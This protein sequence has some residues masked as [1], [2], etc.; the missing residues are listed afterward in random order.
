VAKFLRVYVSASHRAP[1]NAL[2]DALE[3]AGHNVCSL[4]HRDPTPAP[5][6][7]EAKEWQERTAG[8]FNMIRSAD[9]HV[10]ICDGLP[11]PGGKHRESGFAQGFAAG[12]KGTPRCAVVGP[13]ENGMQCHPAVKH[14]AAVEDVVAWVDG[15]AK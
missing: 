7:A 13:V 14:F 6:L 5:P 3:A 2:A 1:A 9:V 12:H 10:T 11:H 8:N 4:W 15:G